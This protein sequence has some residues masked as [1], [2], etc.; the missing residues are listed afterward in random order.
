VLHSRVLRIRFTAQDLLR[1]RFLSASAPL[2]EISLATAALCG[3]DTS[4]LE[5]WRARMRRTFPRE[6]LPLLEL[7]ADAGAVEYLWALDHD[8]DAAVDAVLS[9]PSRYVRESLDAVGRTGSPWTRRLAEGDR[10]AQ[11]VL[12]RALRSALRAFGG[13]YERVR[14][15]LHTDMAHR[16]EILFSGGLEAALESVFRTA[17]WHGDTLELPHANDIDLDLRGRGM[18]LLP[19]AFRIGSTLIG[20]PMPDQPLTVI[21]PAH[22]PMP[23]L[24]DSARTPA[25]TPLLGRT[26]TAV[27][28]TITHNPSSTTSQVA[29]LLGISPG[30]A[31]EHAGVLRDAG[32]ITSHRHRNTVRHVPTKLGLEIG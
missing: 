20:S 26:R 23:L 12:E 28:K 32:L 31:S 14:A 30:R 15:T 17:S 22:I 1:T 6:A 5:P 2:V 29:A 7:I 9:S 21:Y 16:K 27:L 24:E 25:L 18:V 13:E 4:L 8:F 19:T 11:A 3:K 10:A